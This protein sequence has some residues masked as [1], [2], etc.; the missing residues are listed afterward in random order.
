LFR[1]R[2]RRLGGVEDLVISLCAKG[3]TTGEVQAHLAEIYGAQVSRQTISTITDAVLDGLAEWQHRPLDPVYPVIFIDAIQ[4]KIR[5]GQVA[6]RPIYVALA[7]TVDG[8]RDILGLWAGDGGEGAKMLA[9]RLN[10][11]QKPRHTGLLH[12]GLRRTYRSARCGG[13]GLASHRRPNV[14]RALFR[15][16]GYADT[17]AVHAG[18]EGTPIEKVGIIANLRGRRAVRQGHDRA[19]PKPHVGQLIRIVPFAFDSPR[20]SC[21]SAFPGL[22]RHLSIDLEQTPRSNHNSHR[23]LGIIQ[24]SA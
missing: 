19:A 11:D 22:C 3:L 12:P 20:M 7:V 9:A 24:R 14:H 15:C 17:G 4:V 23:P 8:E 10:R 21:R 1:K 18:Q 16:P 2:Q 6:N 5:D 13:A